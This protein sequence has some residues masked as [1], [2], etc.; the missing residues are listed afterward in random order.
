ME[1]LARGLTSWVYPLG[2][3]ITYVVEMASDP[4]AG[5]RHGCLTEGV[6]SDY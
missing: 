5:M 1:L 2:G 3:N 4:A 6:G